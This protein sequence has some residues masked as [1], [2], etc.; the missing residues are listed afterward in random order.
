M[1]KFLKKMLE[2]LGP[3]TPMPIIPPVIPGESTTTI[4][5]VA[6]GDKP[7]K[8][9]RNQLKPSARRKITPRKEST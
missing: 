1:F 9:P 8:S 2:R 5:V 7:K 3:V 4:P 6:I